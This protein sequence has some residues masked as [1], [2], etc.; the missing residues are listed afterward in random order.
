MK[1]HLASIVLLTLATH[2]AQ[3]AEIADS[4]VE[5]T[6]S[7]SGVRH[8]T[9]TQTKYGM[10]YSDVEYSAQGGK[11]VLVLRLGTPEQYALWKQVA[12]PET[13]PV[14]GVG[15]EAFELKMMKSVC[16]RA[17]KN[18][19]CVTP[20]VLPDSPKISDAQVLALLRAAL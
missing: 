18:A 5:K 12:G 16:A 9:K 20:S 19:A 11:Y 4:V 8:T 17:G 15:E 14:T 1:A 13:L 3:A 2:A 6:L 7:V 10:T